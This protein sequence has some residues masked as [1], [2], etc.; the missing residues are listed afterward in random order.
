MMSTLAIVMTLLNFLVIGAVIIAGN[1]RG[2]RYMKRIRSLETINLKGINELMNL[3]EEHYDEKR[4]RSV[5]A[6]M[7]LVLW[8]DNWRE[9][10]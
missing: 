6:N 9:E 1:R 4:T 8:D 2:K 3:L 10:A 7:D 5:L